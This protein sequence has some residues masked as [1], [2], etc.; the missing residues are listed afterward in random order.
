MPGQKHKQVIDKIG[1]L[2]GDFIPAAVF[3]SDDYFR[4]LFANFL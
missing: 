3:S 1:S 2:S 4:G